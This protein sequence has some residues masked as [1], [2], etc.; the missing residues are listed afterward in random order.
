MKIFCCEGREDLI[1]TVHCLDIFSKQ[2]LCFSPERQKTIKLPDWARTQQ[3]ITRKMINE[4][5]A[6]R[7]SYDC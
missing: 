6:M 1:K 5:L 4:K 3:F 7:G 2:D